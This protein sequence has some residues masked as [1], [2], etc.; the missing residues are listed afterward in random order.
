MSLVSELC[1]DACSAKAFSALSIGFVVGVITVLYEI[2]VGA[3]VFS[4]SLAPFVLQGI[5]MML[6]GTLVLSLVIALTSGYRGALVAH[7]SPS[8][9]VLVAVGSTI[10]AEGDT[11]FMTMVAILII[12]AVT[13]GACFLTIGRFRLANLMRF[14]PYPVAGGVLAAAGGTLALAA[15]SMMG[16]TLDRQ[17]LSTLLE[18]AVLWSWGPGVAYGLVLFFVT[19]RWS[20]YLILPVS[21]VLATALYHLSLAFL[22]LSGDAAQAA[23]VSLAGAAEGGLWPAFRPGDLTH[24]DW[25]A[26]AVQIPNMLSLLLVTLICMVVF[27]SG[28]ELVTNRELEWNRE[29]GVTGW[30][31][32]LAGLGGGPAGCLMPGYSKLTQEAG[33]DTRLTGIAAAVVMG[34][35][36]LLGDTIVEL[37]PAPILAGMLLLISLGLLE[38][39]LVTSC[40]RL[41]GTDYAI[42][43]AIFVTVVFVGF[44]AGVGVGIAITTV[45]FAVRL[46]RVDAIEA[47]F[48]ARE[49]H[50]NK[51][52]P[53]AD[54]AILVAEGERVR[55]YR[56]RGY[57]FF[58]SAHSLVERLRQSLDNAP[59]ACILLDF[60][61]VSGLDFSAVNTLCG[62]IRSA[63]DTG[64]Q[65]VLSAAPKNCRDGLERNLPSA[66]SAGLCFERDADRALER[67]EDLV[68]AAR[69]SNLGK[70]GD[71]GDAVL[72][73]FAGDMERHLDR[74]I[75]FE[76]MAHELREWLEVR[77]Y[78]AGETLVATGAPPAGLQLLLMGRASVYDVAGTRLRQCGPG[79]A[80]EPRGAFE[81]Y[82]ATAATIA[83]EPCRT[84]ML[85]S[86][87][88][89]RLEERRGRLML[90]LYGYLLTVETRAESLPGPNWR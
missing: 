39:W 5:G 86:A 24:V 27:L 56:L 79:D 47:T 73:R 51:S 29:F 69:R 6:F 89:Q 9:A 35:V 50:S 22:D 1:A 7:P 32:V 4:G 90:Q 12:G 72:E 68:I 83:D 88:R 14:I 37:I 59:P 45:F 85:T 44:P 75:L 43:L 23:T 84:L 15:L 61:A 80:I 41:P 11:L 60:G 25:A 34:S 62:F 31:S 16:V 81:A 42:I 30:A 52:R 87:V 10:A 8:I 3:L 46:G 40:K 55:A 82:A 2:S 33:A 65:V 63:H 53:I 67:C 71:S 70:E 74:R 19:K 57:I 36:L 28:I 58:G 64:V 13:T 17:T 54:R 26:V 66:V 20:N 78:D 77:D 38:E 18:P 21:F 48:T 49:R 76:D